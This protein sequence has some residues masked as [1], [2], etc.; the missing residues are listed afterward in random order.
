[1]YR[2]YVLLEQDGYVAIVEERTEWSH[3]WVVYLLRNGGW[4]EMIGFLSYGN[5]TVLPIVWRHADIMDV[6]P[7]VGLHLPFLLVVEQN[8][9]NRWWLVYLEYPNPGI[10][11]AFRYLLVRS[12][13][14]EFDS[15]PVME[16]EIVDAGVAASS[17]DEDDDNSVFLWRAGFFEHSD[18]E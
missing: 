17:D 9:D 12:F 18:S 11:H 1:M 8:D 14:M 5:R 7:A 10:E 13:L 2:V 3:W 15:S 4:E 16:V 6:A